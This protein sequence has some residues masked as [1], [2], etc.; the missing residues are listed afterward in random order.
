MSPLVQLCIVVATL[1]MVAI[2]IAAIR[3]MMR[4]EAAT[5]EFTRTAE[6]VR[7]SVEHAEAVTRQVQDLVA[8][9]YSAMAPVRRTAARIDEVAERAMRVS[10]AALDE[11]ESPLRNT[12]AVLAGLRTGTRSLFEAL[13]RRANHMQSNGGHDHD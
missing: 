5:H 3:A 2:A 4:F 13:S 10:H 9:M 6:T 1:A 12:L 11:V 8:S 7:D